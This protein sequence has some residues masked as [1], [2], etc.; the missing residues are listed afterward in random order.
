MDSI[1]QFDQDHPDITRHGQQHLVEV[2]GLRVL[3]RFEF[4]LVDFGD[5]IDQLSDLFAEFLHQLRARNRRVFDNVVQNCGDDAAA[6][7]MQVCK[8]AGNG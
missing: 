7:Q 1:R 6:I 3:S 8:N 4:N 2:L 5:T